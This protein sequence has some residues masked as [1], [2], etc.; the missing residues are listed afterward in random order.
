MAPDRSTTCPGG[1][2]VP[3]GILKGR[4][5]AARPRPD[6]DFALRYLSLIA[7]LDASFHRGPAGRDAAIALLRE[8]L[9]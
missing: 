3:T 6:S 5:A 2:K 7:G 9:G 1:G 8:R 4:Y